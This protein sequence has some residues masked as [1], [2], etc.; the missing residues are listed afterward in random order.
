VKLSDKELRC[1]LTKA[2]GEH[3]REDL[4]WLRPQHIESLSPM[5]IAGLSRKQIAALKAEQ[6]AA[7]TQ[8][9]VKALSLYQM[10]LVLQRRPRV[11][12]HNAPSPPVHRWHEP[13]RYILPVNLILWMLAAAWLAIYW[14]AK[15][16]IFAVKAA[17]QEVVARKS[18]QQVTNK[19]N[20]EN[21]PQR[22]Q[23]QSQVS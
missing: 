7:L 2:P 14:T 1:I 4:L 23:G 16:I 18:E 11:P 22:S 17:K 12:R 8:E 5:Q 10:G 6:I 13:R 21:I 3:T 20:N 19:N 9:Q 15:G